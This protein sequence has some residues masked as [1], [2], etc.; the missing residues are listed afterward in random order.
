M[1]TKK[2]IKRVITVTLIIAAAALW[3]FGVNYAAKLKTPVNAVSTE[4]KETGIEMPT[5]S[6]LV[7]E[8]ENARSVFAVSTEE[9]IE[10]YNSVYRQ[11]NGFDCL[12]PKNPDNWYH[13]S[14]LSP[15][16]G[17]GSV[18]HQFTADKTVWPMPTL[19][20]YTP[21]DENEIFEIR[22]TFDDH[23]YQERFR[24]LFK[25]LCICMEKTLLPGLSEEE[26]DTLFEN[27]YARSYENFFGI[28]AAFD[29]PERPPLDGVYQCGNIGAYSFYGA[30]NIE[31]C[32][33]PLTEN[34]AVFLRDNNTVITKDGNIQW[35]D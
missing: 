10:R 30:G 2:P 1:K 18:R 19:S 20:I 9:L 24:V 23:G 8:D 32:F 15:C 7:T 27:L 29:D 28:H 4:E 21:E 12:D 6:E 26:A 11:R 13:Y 5:L 33:V 25:E 31:I 16:L 35:W 34:A 3:L 22:M 14:E 17:Y